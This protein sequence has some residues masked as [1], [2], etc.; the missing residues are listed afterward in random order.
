MANDIDDEIYPDNDDKI[1]CVPIIDSTNTTTGADQST[2]LTGLTNLKAYLAASESASSDAAALDPSL[3]ITLTE[4]GSTGIYYGS[5]PGSAKRSASALA[6][7]ADGTVIWR[8]WQAGTVYHEKKSVIWRKN[9][10]P[11]A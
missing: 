5:M 3:V 8:H 6:A 9:G 11:A 4:A 2:P 7:L 10:R 1:R